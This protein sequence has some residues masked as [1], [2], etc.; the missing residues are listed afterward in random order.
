MPTTTDTADIDLVG[1]LRALWE[2]V[3]APKDRWH[4]WSDV[5]ARLRDDVRTGVAT[6]EADEEGRRQLGR[7][8]AGESVDAGAGLADELGAAIRRLA[9]LPRPDGKHPFLEDV[10]VGLEAAL[11]LLT[12]AACSPTARARFNALAAQRE[13]ASR[14]TGS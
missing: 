6:L 7:I 12:A 4:P 10:L 11:A 5:L 3:P 14:P 13:P 1:E 8:L 9:E 2:R